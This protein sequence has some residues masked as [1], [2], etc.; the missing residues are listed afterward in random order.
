MAD[1]GKGDEG[2]FGGGAGEQLE[3][4]ERDSGGLSLVQREEL[5]PPRPG[6]HTHRHIS[7]RLIV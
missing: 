5:A 1:G 7:L 6:T 4:W 2:R 3:G